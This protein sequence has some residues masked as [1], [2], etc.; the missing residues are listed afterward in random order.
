[1]G[2]K[3]NNRGRHSNEND[4]GN[5]NY[6]RVK[7]HNHEFLSSTDYAK[8]EGVEHNHR[9]AGVTGPPMGPGKYHFH[10]IAVFT[11]TFD[12]HFHKICDTTG[13][14]L[15]LSDGKHIHLVEGTTEPEDQHD[16]DYFFT[17]LIQDPTNVP[18]DRNC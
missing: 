8:D 2:Y 9:I 15:W 5:E 4:E 10:K 11:D 17:T 7:N 13:P 6:Y 14:A 1:M 12:D 16:H 18:E 3:Y